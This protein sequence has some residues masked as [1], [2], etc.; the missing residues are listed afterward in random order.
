MFHHFLWEC[1]LAALV[2]GEGKS[3]SHVAHIGTAAFAG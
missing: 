2:R 1:E 3:F